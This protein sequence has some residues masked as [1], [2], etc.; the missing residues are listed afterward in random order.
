MDIHKEF[1]LDVFGG[2][3]TEMDLVEDDTGGHVDFPCAN[4]GSKSND[5]QSYEVVRHGQEEDIIVLDTV[6]L[7][8][9]VDGIGCLL[10]VLGPRLGSRLGSG[11]GG[12]RNGERRLRLRGDNRLLLFLGRRLGASA[13]GAVGLAHAVCRYRGQ[14]NARGY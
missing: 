3:T 5:T 7:V 8:G 14:A 1:A 9:G 13:P 11:L 10:L 4:Q 2:E 12:S 6:R